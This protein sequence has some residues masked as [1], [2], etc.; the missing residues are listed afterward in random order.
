MSVGSCVCH[1]KRPKKDENTHQWESNTHYTI[2][3]HSLSLI[4]SKVCLD[5]TEGMLRMKCTYC[6][7]GVLLMKPQKRKLYKLSLRAHMESRITYSDFRDH[8]RS[9]CVF[10]GPL[11]NHGNKVS[12]TNTPYI[13]IYP[14]NQHSRTAYGKFTMHYLSHDLLHYELP[15]YILSK[16]SQP[17]YFLQ[18]NIM[19]RSSKLVQSLYFDRQK[20]DKE[21]SFN[22]EM[23]VKLSQKEYSFMEFF[24]SS[25]KPKHRSP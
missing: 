13:N 20:S 2:T 7:L 16:I 11:K 1:S 23:D 24:G 6:L 8:I 3:I 15:W 14:N 25:Y 22:S 10:T 21:F 17:Q 12:V 5:P 18:C 19:E 4:D 9:T